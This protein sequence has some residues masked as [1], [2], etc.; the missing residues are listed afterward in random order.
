MIS[1]EANEICEK[2]GRKTIAAEHVMKA[3][4]ELGFSEYITEI[5]EVATE[6]R[7]QVKVGLGNCRGV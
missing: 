6:H 7:E 4:E 5:N 1:S 3:L 2:D